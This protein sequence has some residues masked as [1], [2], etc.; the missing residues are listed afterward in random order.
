MSVHKITIRPKEGVPEGT[1]MT[2]ANTQVLIDGEPFKGL[3]ALA[4]DVETGSIARV[5]VQMFAQ[6]DIEAPVEVIREEDD[7]KA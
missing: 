2:G 4:F 7:N 3:T 1:P 5:T 6:V